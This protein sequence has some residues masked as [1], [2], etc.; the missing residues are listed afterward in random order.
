[1][2]D[3]RRDLLFLRIGFDLIH[4]RHGRRETKD[5]QSDFPFSTWLLHGRAPPEHG[6]LRGGTCTGAGPALWALPARALPAQPLHGLFTTSPRHREPSLSSSSP[7]VSSL[8]G[9][10]WG[11]H[12]PPLAVLPVGPGCCFPRPRARF[13]PN[14]VRPKPHLSLSPL[15]SKCCCLLLLF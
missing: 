13:L 2:M 8:H 9:F 12:L 14:T 6:A 4:S 1:M 10:S 11:S 7:G 3:G 5:E 15:L